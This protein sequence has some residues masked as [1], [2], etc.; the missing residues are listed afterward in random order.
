MNATPSNFRGVAYLILALFIMS[1]QG[2]A[3]KF[4]G[5]DYSIMEIVLLRSVVALPAS[6]VLFRLEGQRGLPTTKRP[7]LE[8]LRGL[9]LFISYTTAFMGLA[10]LPLGEYEAIRFSAPLMI[11]V[12]SVVMLGEKVGFHRWLALAVGFAGVL[13]MVRPGSASFNLGSVFVLVAM[14]FYA[15][16]VILTRRLQAT[17]SSATMGYYSTILYLVAALVLSPLVL[18]VGEMPDAQPGIAFLFRGWAMPT[19][20]DAVIM[21]GLGLVWVGG[22]Y[23]VAR[24]YSTAQ[25]SMVASFEYVSLPISVMWGFLIWH[26]IPTWTTWVGAGLTLAGGLYIL[27]RERGGQAATKALPSLALAESEQGI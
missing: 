27:Y 10:S 23:F 3:V 24:A 13:F 26:E 17:D 1:L 25:A 5:G 16:S 11:T 15:L 6:I 8:Y 7:G 9:C 12:L 4:I 21:A 20:L 22:M 18:L 19:P 14:L 2:V